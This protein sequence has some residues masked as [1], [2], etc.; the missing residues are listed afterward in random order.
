MGRNLNKTAGFPHCL[1]DG[2]RAE[3]KENRL[4]TRLLLL[5]LVIIDKMTFVFVFAGNSNFPVYFTCHTRQCC[6][7]LRL[8]YE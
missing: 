3:E 5:L 7:S 8:V 1:D 4:K 6:V 2:I